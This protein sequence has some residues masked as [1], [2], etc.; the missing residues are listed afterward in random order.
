MLT[1]VGELRISLEFARLGVALFLCSGLCFCVCT[2]SGREKNI[3]GREGE[4]WWWFVVVCWGV[5]VVI[6]GVD[7]RHRYPKEK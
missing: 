2:N 1:N 3:R 7:N 6:D 4:T 5:A